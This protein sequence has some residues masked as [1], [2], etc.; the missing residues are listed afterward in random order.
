MIE[1]PSNKI[2]FRATIG[3]TDVN[4]S[5]VDVHP[6][7]EWL[8]VAATYD[9]SNMRIY[10]NGVEKNS[11]AQTG[12]LG[13]TATAMRIGTYNLN[14]YMLHGQVK[15]F[16]IFNRALTAKEIAIESDMLNSDKKMKIGKDGTLYIA[17]DIIEGL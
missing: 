14:A 17:G 16:K 7:N 15:D 1:N 6:L 13:S 5:D 12:T 8:H 2:R 9:G 11:R 10:V 4:V 3:G